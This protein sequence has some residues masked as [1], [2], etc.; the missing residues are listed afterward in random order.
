MVP[1]G[2]KA[3]RLSINHTTRT[4]YHH[5]HYPH[6]HHLL[7]V[8]QTRQYQ[9]NSCFTVSMRIAKTVLSKCTGCVLISDSFAVLVYV[10]HHR[11]IL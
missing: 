9:Q 6:H 8:L 10:K 7:R 3:K 1:A 2:N 4:I 11:M 5:H